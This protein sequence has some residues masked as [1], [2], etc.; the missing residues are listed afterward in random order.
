MQPENFRRS[1]IQAIINTN[2]AVYFGRFAWLSMPTP[3]DDEFKKAENLMAVRNES[4]GPSIRTTTKF[5]IQITIVF[6]AYFIAGKLGQATANIRSNNLGPVWPAYGVALAA[7]LLLGYRVWPGIAVGAFLVAFLS[8]APHLAAVGQ[9]AGG[10][11]AALTGAFLLRRIAKFNDSMSRLRD[12]LAL[13]LF[14][15]LGS[16]MVSA[17]IGVSVLYATHIHAY[18]GLGSAWLI[19]WLGDATGV[20]LV[21]PL[22]LTIPDLLK[23]RP[24]ARI[25][26]LGMLLSLL[27]LASLL[28]F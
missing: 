10:T 24:W 21:T 12:A 4:I 19:Y 25:A 5:L 13:I 6:L 18:S 17:S 3:S 1:W 27:S 26:E 20:L 16:A 7:V 11:L 9:A 8:P 2:F 15:A 22:V 23:I 14:G 28:I